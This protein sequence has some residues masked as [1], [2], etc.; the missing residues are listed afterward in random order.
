LTLTYGLRWEINPLLKGKNLANDPFTVIGLNDPATLTL[1]PRRFTTRH[2]ET[3]HLEWE[4]LISYNLPSTQL[5]NIAR[6]ALG[7]WSVDSFILTR[8]APPLT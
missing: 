5:N 7:G 4:L 2:M 6:A 3:S 1:A 8:T